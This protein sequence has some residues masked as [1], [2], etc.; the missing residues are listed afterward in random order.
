MRHEPFN[1]LVD[2]ECR[3]NIYTA[4]EDLD[5]LWDEVNV[6]SVISMWRLGTSI[7]DMAAALHRDPDEVAILV[8]DLAKQRKISQRENGVY[9]KFVREGARHG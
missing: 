7:Y 3:R 5:F 1:P 9:G 2:G 6:T 8:I 4:C